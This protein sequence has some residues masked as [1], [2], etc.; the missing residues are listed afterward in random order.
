MGRLKCGIATDTHGMNVEEGWIGGCF[1]GQLPPVGL[2]SCAS[3][4]F[5][6]GL[7]CRGLSWPQVGFQPLLSLRFLPWRCT[8]FS[9]FTTSSLLRAR[10]RK[11]LGTGSKVWDSDWLFKGFS[12]FLTSLHLKW[13]GVIKTFA[14]VIITKYLRCMQLIQS[15]CQ[16]LLDAGSRLQVVKW[17]FAGCRR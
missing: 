17:S 1:G 11:P 13:Y 3:R 8:S 16:V 4:W 2:L 10:Y 5:K 7:T 15:R 9:F 12:V 6:K 14:I